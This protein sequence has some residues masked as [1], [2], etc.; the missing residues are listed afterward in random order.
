MSQVIKVD[1]SHHLDINGAKTL[2][3]VELTSASIVG[4]GTYREIEK[5]KTHLA[6]AKGMYKALNILGLMSDRYAENVLDD[7]NRIADKLDT[8][9]REKEAESMARHLRDSGQPCIPPTKE[10]EPTEYESERPIGN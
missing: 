5:A 1:L 3:E 4:R 10:K 6:E 8:L 2:I 7:L 9:Q